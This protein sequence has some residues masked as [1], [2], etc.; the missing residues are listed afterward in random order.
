[1][2]LYALPKMAGLD[3]VVH[4]CAKDLAT[5]RWRKAA[6]PIFFLL[7]ID[8]ICQRLSAST[9]LQLDVD[10]LDRQSRHNR[11]MRK[12]RA[13]ARAHATMVDPFRSAQI[14]Q[15]AVAAQLA[16]ASGFV[17][18]S[19]QDDKSAAW[20]QQG[21]MSL[22]T[23]DKLHQRAV[24]RHHPDVLNILQIFWGHCIAHCP[25]Y[26]CPS[27]GGANWQDDGGPG[28]SIGFGAYK[29][30]FERIY[31]AVLEEWDPDDA[32]ATIAEDWAS[33]TKGESE[34]SR[35]AFFDSIFE[36][37]D[38]WCATIEVQDYVSFIQN[39]FDAVTT[40]GGWRATTSVSFNAAVFGNT[41]TRDM[42]NGHDTVVAAQV[43][44]A[45][46]AASGSTGRS[47]STAMNDAKWISA[48]QGSR[49]HHSA[50]GHRNDSNT[51]QQPAS[52]LDEDDVNIFKR[53]DV[54]S[55][56]PNNMQGYTCNDPLVRTG[57]AD[58]G[59]NGRA[60][61]GSRQSRIRNQHER[62]GAAII[63]QSRIRKKKACKEK[64]KR[65]E[66]VTKINK[67]ARRR[68]SSF[69]K[70]ADRESGSRGQEGGGQAFSDS[71]K[72]RLMSPSA[73]TQISRQVRSSSTTCREHP[74][75]EF[76]R[77][78]QEGSS[79][80]GSAYPNSPESRGRSPRYA[81]RSCWTQQLGN[82]EYGK[83]TR[84]SDH[85]IQGSQSLRQENGRDAKAPPWNC[86][87]PSTN[88]NGTPA[89]AA[90]P[91][92]SNTYRS[93]RS[94]TDRIAQSDL[95]PRSPRLLPL[96]TPY[97]NPAPFD[98][99]TCA[100]RRS[101]LTPQY[102]APV[103]QPDQ[104][105]RVPLS[106]RL[107]ASAH[108]NTRASADWYPPKPRLLPLTLPVLPRFEV[109][110]YSSTRLDSSEWNSTNEALLRTVQSRET[111][112]NSTSSSTTPPGHG[113]CNL[114]GRL[115]LMATPGP[116]APQHPFSPLNY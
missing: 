36:L 89:P 110:G 30:L 7:R 116:A 71:P 43:P 45:Q 55:A 41:C 92:P 23:I 62:R 54:N 70:P 115:S 73:D 34:L 44:A 68:C 95:L 6:R 51:L 67:Q 20:W 72:G 65:K 56:K 48:G 29:M 88:G 12:L 90:S 69:R 75:H 104:R 46:S 25:Y 84:S 83:D 81:Q 42:G 50:M 37:S 82:D 91:M 9:T 78:S 85:F 76:A 33:D 53:K 31:R 86:G 100:V 10:K 40:D 13:G 1:M 101:A 59:S 106:P 32:E 19:S 98:W 2:V 87:R 103:R 18:A 93:G 58:K 112:P 96:V 17:I 26:E 28:R 22:Y 94:R 5:S 49:N 79:Q 52:V 74:G 27:T 47:P 66:A 77:R 102:E 60:T 8:K 11:Y 4:R 108:S 97:S 3:D 105:G 38:N 35:E 24:L 61:V 109:Y 39:L 16:M 14:K 111:W 21:D 15:R 63:L 57:D 99:Q 113:L 107:A 64:S 114:L 80:W